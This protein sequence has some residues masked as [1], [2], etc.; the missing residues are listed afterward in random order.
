MDENVDGSDGAPLFFTSVQ[1][2][3]A[4]SATAGAGGSSS[5]DPSR[6]PSAISLDASRIRAM[7]EAELRAEILRMLACLRRRPLGEVASGPAY[8]DGTLA[9]KSMTAVWILSTVGKALGRRLVRLSDVD[10]ESLRS[11]GGVSRLIKTVTA[12]G[13]E[14]RAAA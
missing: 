10:R 13:A 4:V 1:T 3:V 14:L 8:T 12:S 9:I 7:S 6:G 5:W 11:V 2:E